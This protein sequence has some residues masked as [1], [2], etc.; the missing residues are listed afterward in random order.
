MHPNP[1]QTYA[2]HLW[3]QKARFPYELHATHRPRFG[4]PPGLPA[5]Q[6]QIEGRWRSWIGRYVGTSRS[7]PVYTTARF[8]AVGERLR[9]ARV[10][11]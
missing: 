2:N 11:V 9:P 4:P 7:D 8:G 3:N 6:R 1:L 10:R 5:P